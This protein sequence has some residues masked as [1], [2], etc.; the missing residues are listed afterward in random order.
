MVAVPLVARADDCDRLGKDLTPFGS[1]KAGNKDGSIPAYDGGMKAPPAGW[2]PSQGYVDPFASDKPLFV[3]TAA[4]MDQ[5]KDKLTPGLMGMLK[6]YSTFKVPVYPTHRTYAPAQKYVDATKANCGKVK[7][8]GDQHLINYDYSEFRPFPVPKNGNEVIINHKNWWY[9]GGYN[10]CGDWLPTK[11]NGEYYRVGFC[12]DLISG[13]NFDQKQPNNIFSFYGLYDAPATLIGT[14]YLVRDPIDYSVKNREAWIYNAGQRRVR[15]APDVA[16]D[17]IDD[18]TEGMRTSDDWWGYNGSLERYNFKLIG[19]KEMYIPYNSYKVNDSKL[20]YA[21][22]VEKGHLKSDLFRY[23]LHRVWHVEATLKPGMSHV[24]AKRVFYMDEDSGMIA[25]V[26][27]YDS[28]G[29]LWR[30]YIEP[31]LQAYEANVMFQS[32]YL[33]HDL[34]NGNFIASMAINERKA[35]VYKWG[36]PAKWSD[37]QVDAIR[38]KGTR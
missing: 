11:A 5:Y 13:S 25:L 33:V 31:L 24:V 38:R 16:F 26:D 23:E 12:E 1:E 17:N 35:P 29:S 4:N 14:V 34:S 18:G 6:K 7:L 28:R 19:K 15:R 30:V 21:D 10:R 20:K 2:N 36:A 8:E 22:M 9:G 32:P 27:G 37:F 3:I